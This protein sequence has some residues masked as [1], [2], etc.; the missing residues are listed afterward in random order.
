MKKRT[1]IILCFLIFT[2]LL[3]PVFAPAA[4]ADVGNSEFGEGGG[5]DFGGDWDF[6]SGYDDDLDLGGLAILPFFGGG[7]SVVIIVILIIVFAVLKSKGIIGTQGN[8]SARPNGYPGG[9]SGNFSGQTQ[10]NFSAMEAAAAAAVA[11]TDPAF[12]LSEF[13]AFAGD[14]FLRTQECWESKSLPILRPYISERYY[15]TLESQLSEFINGKKTNHL[16]AQTVLDTYMTDFTADGKTE[17]IT[18]RLRAS[19]LDYTTPDDSPDIILSGSKTERKERTYRLEFVRSAG[20]KTSSEK[21]L[22]SK[23]CPACGAPLEVTSAGV[24][25]YCKTIITSGEYGWVLN[26]YTLWR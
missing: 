6:S 14:V 24:C 8:K 1:A 13:K 15:N 4:R 5:W 22:L 19:L 12:S 9:V 18:V 11:N 23:E 20:T 21:E 10:Q 17:R 7:G 2:A 16:D 25:A 3:L 26:Q